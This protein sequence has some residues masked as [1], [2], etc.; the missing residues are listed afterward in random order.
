LEEH[1]DLLKEVEKLRG[2]VI[3]EIVDIA[4]DCSF[5]GFNEELA[6]EKATHLITQLFDVI[7]AKTR[8]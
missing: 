8:D 2:E 3:G 5:D 6:K 4:H 7:K 1:F